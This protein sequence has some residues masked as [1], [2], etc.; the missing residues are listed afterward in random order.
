MSIAINGIQLD[1]EETELLALIKSIPTGHTLDVVEITDR[2]SWSVSEL[3]RTSGKLLSKGVPICF[4]EWTR[5]HDLAGPDEPETFWYARDLRDLD[6]MSRYLRFELEE[7]EEMLKGVEVAR[8]RL[9][10][11]GSDR[12]GKE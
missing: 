2:L 12:V 1:D 10:T 9:T 6:R 11:N 3:F 8:P 5:W 4:S 7:I